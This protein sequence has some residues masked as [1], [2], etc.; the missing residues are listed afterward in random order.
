MSDP[1]AMILRFDGDPDDLVERYEKARQLWIAAQDDDYEPPA[2][3]AACKAEDGIAIV[4]GWPS[5]EAHKAFAR[6]IRPHLKA[7]DM[8]R[9]DGH[10]HLRIAKLG[11]D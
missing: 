1:V 10:E 8:G 6:G 5:D 7:V 4:I 2:F 3:C 11:W 9:P